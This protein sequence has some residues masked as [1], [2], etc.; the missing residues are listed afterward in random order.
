MEG[1]AGAGYNEGPSSGPTMAKRKKR[2]RFR[3][4]ARRLVLL[5]MCC[6]LVLYIWRDSLVFPYVRDTLEELVYEQTGVELKIGKL[7]GSIFD[8]LELRDVELVRMPSWGVLRELSVGKLR[9]EYSLA[10]IDRVEA[11]DLHAIIEALPMDEWDDTGRF[12]PEVPLPTLPPIVDVS[13]ADV[14]V[15]YWWQEE[16]GNIADSVVVKDG[17]IFCDRNEIVIAS[18]SVRAVIVPHGS[19][20]LTGKH[21]EWGFYDL[22]VF[23]DAELLAEATADLT[24][25]PL[26]SFPFSVQF[27]YPGMTPLSTYA[28]IDQDSMRGRVVAD[29]L[30]FAKLPLWFRVPDVTMDGVFDGTGSFRI[31]PDDP[32]DQDAPTEFAWAEG[33]WDNAQLGVIDLDSADLS[34]EYDGGTVIFEHLDAY[35]ETAW[36]KAQGARF[37]AEGGW[38]GLLGSLYIEDFEGQ[39]ADLAELFPDRQPLDELGAGLPFGLRIDGNVDEEVVVLDAHLT[40]DERAATVTNAFLFIAPG[41]PARS[42]M[43]IENIAL[44]GGDVQSFLAHHG[45]EVPASGDVAGLAHL[46]GNFIDPRLELDLRV[47]ELVVADHRAEVVTSSVVI[48][49]GGVTVRGMTV[50]EPQ[51]GLYMAGGGTYDFGA[52]SLAFVLRGR[53]RPT[54]ITSGA[55][56]TEAAIAARVE[57]SAARPEAWVQVRLEDPSLVGL[58]LD[59][60]AFTFRLN[61]DRAGFEGTL[62][63]PEAE[64][65]WR[66][67]TPDLRA[68]TIAIDLRSLAVRD[69]AHWFRAEAG[70][71]R[72]GADFLRLE[73]LTLRGASARVTLDAV[74][75]YATEVGVSVDAVDVVLDELLAPWLEAELPE[76]PFDRLTGDLLFDSSGVAF[77][78]LFARSEEATLS[79]SGRL[80]FD[81]TAVIGLLASAVDL[82]RF[83]D[84]LGELPPVRLNTVS[85]SIV[86]KLPR[87]DAKFS[88]SASLP[89]QDSLDLSC[90]A[91]VVTES[92]GFSIPS[93]SLRVDGVTVGSVT[94]RMPY[95]LFDGDEDAMPNVVFA[96]D[97]AAES[98][99]FA[100][101]REVWSDG[102][103]Q[104]VLHYGRTRRGLG[105]TGTI[106]GDSCRLGPGDWAQPYD[107]VVRLRPER[108]GHHSELWLARPGPLGVETLLV[109][110]GRVPLTVAREIGWQPGGE[111]DLRFT[112]RPLHPGLV[113]RPLSDTLWVGGRLSFHG[114]LKGL[115]TRPEIDLAGELENLHM[116]SGAISELDG[117]LWLNGR[118]P[119][120]AAVEVAGSLGPFSCFAVGDL[121]RR[122]GRWWLDG[123]AHGW[124]EEL[125]GLPSLFPK[126]L[127]YAGGAATFDIAAEG[128]LDELRTEGRARLRD[129]TLKAVA[130]LPAVENLDLDLDLR[131]D[132]IEVVSGRGTLGGSDFR[133]DGGLRVG[134]DPLL[135]LALDGENLLLYRDEGTVTRGD[136]KLRVRGPLSSLVI[137][138]T[139]TL[140]YG[141]V[142]RDL[143]ANPLEA[144]LETGLQQSTPWRMAVRTGPLSTARYDLT[145]LTDEPV[146]VR[147]VLFRGE[148]ST[149]A[150]KLR[151]TGRNPWLEGNL[152]IDRADYF[153]PT[154]VIRGEVGQLSFSADR[155]FD[156]ELTIQGRSRILNY[157]VELRVVGNLSDPELS[158]NTLPPMSD[159]DARNFLLTGR[160]P[161]GIAGGA[162]DDRRAAAFGNVAVFVARDYFVKSLSST[163]EWESFWRDVLESIEIEVGGGAVDETYIEVG[164][165]VAE[166]VLLEG[167]RLYVIG[168][169]SS[170]GSINGGLRIVFSIP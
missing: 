169:R 56:E 144:L 146:E 83:I 156:P 61:R 111:L 38:E 34:F 91:E 163:N 105:L 152:T 62:R 23:H 65:V 104:A 86:G 139:V 113:P 59:T 138:D 97:V 85:G 7:Q 106:T 90:L 103:L 58:E 20:R 137:G 96:L 73:P 108:S 157:Q 72:A 134:T 71:L 122:D 14:T 51:N 140:R 17:R 25:F 4:W 36:F 29:S 69:G 15:T 102:R 93:S 166:E 60:A 78:D 101:L 37:F 28:V 119:D 53:A 21:H 100:P 46:W 141:R 115:P 117:N 129:A 120:Q 67:E 142:T 10:Q 52:D 88:I 27:R 110:A 44:T 98:L 109:A 33:F 41:A 112:S 42:F 84:P 132:S 80:G 43:D 47:P 124:A 13:N 155:P 75:D 64:L 94:G 114:T 107:F 148:L 154:T 8:A 48:D 143:L 160:P 49:T 5:L 24:G 95:G 118:W 127:R 153:L 79:A 147:S 162:F 136:V 131:G 74:W 116:L 39:T 54:H 18:P 16:E 9:I 168:E 70:Q 164:L 167:D 55:L 50:R 12:F 26:G 170:L 11:V 45:V 145:F 31:D 32:D 30:D 150:L 35:R 126:R 99:R 76:L 161:E 1:P 40:W 77:R 135:N 81:S 125:F 165:P 6:A 123:E 149:T 92:A 128:P 151:G 130:D 22:K 19:V 63:A 158:I 121:E 133:L 3:R 68:D 82:A 2:K 89:W 57:G 87:P 159:N 66:A